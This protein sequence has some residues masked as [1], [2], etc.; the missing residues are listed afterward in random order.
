MT[1]FPSDT[2]PAVDTFDLFDTLF[3]EDI[4]FVGNATWRLLFSLSFL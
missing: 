3:C 1:A 2:W 4:A